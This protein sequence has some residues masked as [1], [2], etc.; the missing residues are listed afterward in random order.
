M[1]ILKTGIFDNLRDVGMWKWSFI[2][3]SLKDK[4]L[5]PWKNKKPYMSLLKLN[6]FII[7]LF[8]WNFRN[9]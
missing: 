3:K 5:K 7:N 8:S 1:S 4:N 2:K 6:N 9:I